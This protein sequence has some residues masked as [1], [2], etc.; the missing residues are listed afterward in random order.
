VFD[1]FTRLKQND[2]MEIMTQVRSFVLIGVLLCICGCSEP[3]APQQPKAKPQSATGA[4]ALSSSANDSSPQAGAQ[5]ISASPNPV[6]VEPGKDGTTKIEWQ[7]GDE[8]YAEVYV[9]TDGQEEKLFT[10]GKNNG[11]NDAKWIKNGSRYVFTLYQGKDHTKKL[12]S[13]VVTTD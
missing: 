9:A 6:H 5:R 8:S 1:F 2:G 3:V 10:S 11:S 4:G 12:A 13:V 7:T